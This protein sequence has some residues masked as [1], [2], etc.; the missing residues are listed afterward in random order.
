MGWMYGVLLSK[1]RQVDGSEKVPRLDCHILD[2]STFLA[3][4]PHLRR[5]YASRSSVRVL[6]RGRGRGGRRLYRGWNG[7]ACV[8]RVGVAEKKRQKAR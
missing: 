7:G 5:Q 6:E 1:G 8:G 3:A 2:F 4:T